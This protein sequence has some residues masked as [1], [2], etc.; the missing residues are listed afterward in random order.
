MDRILLAAENNRPHGARDSGG[1][2]WAKAHLAPDLNKNMQKG[3]GLNPAA[4]N[5]TEDL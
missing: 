1:R 3:L 4:R 5:R 2:S